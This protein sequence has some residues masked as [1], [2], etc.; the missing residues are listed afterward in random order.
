MV[1]GPNMENF[2]A[3]A[4]AFV[5]QRGA[6]QVRNVA[7]LES[8]L[9]RLLADPGELRLLGENARQTVLANQGALERT[10]RLVA[11][12]VGAAAQSKTH[13]SGGTQSF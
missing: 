1:F 4:A 13:L 5:K 3:I 11:D 6:V 2:E 8:A 10:T 9:A 7:E 12:C